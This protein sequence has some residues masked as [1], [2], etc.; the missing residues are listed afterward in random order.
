MAT[1]RQIERGTVTLPSAT[2]SVT[3]TLT[4]TLLDTN[5]TLL[6]FS[7]Q[8][9]TSRSD[10]GLVR[11]VV[12]N[13]TTLTFDRGS[14]TSAPA[15][16][17]E[18]Q[19]VEWTAGVTVQRGVTAMTAISSTDVTVNTRDL[20]KSFVVMA[21]VLSAATNFIGSSIVGGWLT[22][23]TNLHLQ[24]GATGSG[25]FDVAWQI[26]EYDA[27]SVQADRITAASTD[28]T[29]TATVT[30][31]NL[32]KSWLVLNFETNAGTSAQIGDRLWR[33]ELT[34]TTTLTFTREVAP[35]SGAGGTLGWQLVEFTDATSVQRGQLAFTTESSKTAT[36]TS[37][38]TTRAIVS[39]AGYMNTMGSTPKIDVADPTV[40]CFQLTLTNA[41]TLT[42]ARG[43]T[44]QNGTLQWFAVEFP[45]AG[46]TNVNLTDTLSLADV[47]SPSASIAL[48]DAMG[49]A[50]AFSPSASIPVADTL[51]LADAAPVASASIPLTETVTLV[52][53]FSGAASVPTTDT[54][55][56]ADA[57]TAGLVIALTDSIAL[58]DANPVLTATIPV[59]DALDV[60]D[61]LA[62]P[63]VAL[64]LAD[65]LV[66]ADTITVL[67][68]ERI[69]IADVIALVD[70][71]T[72]T[73]VGDFSY[74]LGAPSTYWKAADVPRRWIAGAPAGRR[75]RADEVAPSPYRVEAPC[76]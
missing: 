71:I 51:A 74:T 8:P 56:L 34:N 62:G 45:S 37:V 57:I 60:V 58:T 18:Y 75:L 25:T 59:A 44:T 43:A 2:A 9:S 28:A 10:R 23:S 39:A 5:K 13:T 48:T 12:T 40:T 76:R 22:T 50:D 32:A 66:L 24:K 63:L 47:V 46:A 36:L 17:V 42:A 67:G 26:I 31:V 11:G 1:L 29:R 7:Y 64:A 72:V 55:S 52:D 33:G 73:E 61:A 49:V 65:T 70:T 6:L 54:L 20:T 68:E 4:T 16:T 19:V 15:I 41:T 3:K 69:A 30:A 14:A 38:D 21:G 35:A 53:S 27:C